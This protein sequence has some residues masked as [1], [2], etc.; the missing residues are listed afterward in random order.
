M[1]YN[2]QN[3]KKENNGIYL[4]YSGNNN[5]SGN[6]VINNMAGNQWILRK[7]GV[8]LELYEF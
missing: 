6:L 8:N 1:I 4:Y 7:G 5:L 3:I 2:F